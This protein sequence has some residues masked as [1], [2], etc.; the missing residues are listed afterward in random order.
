[1]KIKKLQTIFVVKCE[2]GDLGVDGW[3]GLKCSS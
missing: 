1:M 2:R 3:T